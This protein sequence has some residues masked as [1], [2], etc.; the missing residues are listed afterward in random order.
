MPSATVEYTLESAEE[1][2]TFSAASSSRVAA[3][4]V[5][6]TS[7]SIVSEIRA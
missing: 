5:N 3:A 6:A 7:T 1:W 4:N 2:R